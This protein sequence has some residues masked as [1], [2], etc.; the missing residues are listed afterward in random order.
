ML[1]LDSRSIQVGRKTVRF[2]AIW[3]LVHVAVY[4]G[5]IFHLGPARLGQTWHELRPFFGW[6]AGG[7]F[8]LAMVLAI[9]RPRFAGGVLGAYLTL[10]TLMLLGLSHDAVLVAKLAVLLLWA[11]CAVS[12]MRQL[13]AR[14]AG[15]R[16]ATWGVSAASVY[17]ALIPLCFLLGIIH[18]I[19]PSVVASLA[20]VTAL[21]GA[22]D[23]LRRLPTLPARCQA[24]VRAVWH[25]G[26]RIAGGDLVRAGDQVRVR[27]HVRSP[28][29]FH[30]RTPA[31]HP[32]G[33][34]GPRHIAPVCLLV[35][36]SADGRADLLR[37]VR[38]LG[39]GCGGEMVLVA[40]LA[41][42][43]SVGGRGGLQAFALAKLGLFAGAAVL[44]CPLLLWVSRVAV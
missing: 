8:A 24:A 1:T 33:G 30:A 21:P 6:Q 41:G 20:V 42:L 23:W 44:G 26:S 38:L 16:Y 12:S 3:F 28:L 2:V 32:S 39:V 9:K 29:G 31:V 22:I 34:V 18:A 37:G 13:L 43:D 36:A 25:C 7:F 4:V 15:E 19:T 11:V 27:Q 5:M 10:S 40:R 35:S 14:I 17:V